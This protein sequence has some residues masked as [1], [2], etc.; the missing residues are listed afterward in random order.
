[1]KVE[2]ICMRQ[3]IRQLM[4]ECGFT[5]ETIK[6]L[7]EDAVKKEAEKVVKQ[8]VEKLINRGFIKEALENE[9]HKQGWGSIKEQV[10]RE[11]RNMRMNVDIKFENDL[12]NYPRSSETLSAEEVIN[13]F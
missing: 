12:M 5:K 11:V 2:E 10:Q 7:V 8:E 6:G 4:A 3:E 1:M 9:I 13:R